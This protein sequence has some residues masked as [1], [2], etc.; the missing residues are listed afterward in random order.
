VSAAAPLLFTSLLFAANTTL[1][2][3]AEWGDED[4]DDVTVLEGE[5]RAER[6]PPITTERS[7]RPSELASAQPENALEGIAGL[8]LVRDGGPLAPARLQLRG[9]RGARVHAELGGLALDDPATGAI[10]PA[11]WP[12]LLAPHVT[13]TGGASSGAPGG[14]L[15][16]DADTP[17]GADVFLRAGLGTLQTTRLDASASA[18]TPAGGFV[19]GG[20]TAA[21]TQGDF[22]Y[23]PFANASD[24]A[25]RTNNDQR[26]ASLFL[27]AGG[28]TE[29]GRSDVLLFAAAREGGV[30]GFATAPTDALRARRLFLGARAALAHDADPA[31]VTLAVDGRF[32]QRSTWQRRVA[33]TSVT[34]FSWGANTTTTIHQL[35]DGVASARGRV[36]ADHLLAE[37]GLTR[38]RGGVHADAEHPL[39]ATGD[40][41][42]VGAVGLEVLTPA[43]STSTGLTLLPDLS[44]GLDARLLSGLRAS[45][46][47]GHAG[48]APTLDEL[49]APRGVV[50]GNPDLQPE[51]ATD[52]ELALL[53]KL[54]DIVGLRFATFAGR[55]EDTILFVNRNAF[56][57]APVNTGP[58]WRA[59]VEGTLRVQP[60]PLLAGEVTGQTL[61]SFVEATGGALPVAPPFAAHM[62]AQLGNS[63]GAQ[64]AATLRARAGAPSTL[65]G[66]LPTDGYALVDV[67][68]RFPLGPAVYLT[69]AVTNVLDTLDARDVNLLPLPGRQLFIAIEVRS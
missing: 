14:R 3:E 2:D 6:A 48:R 9:L 13:L 29:L 19:Q 26:L 43:A 20:A 61:A 17:L 8:T 15:R 28:A 56:E 60:H 11:L 46:R 32:S 27:R 33:P 38:L 39:T 37:H 45:L 10:D 41:R 51:R 36:G 30:P 34:S 49:Y 21:L 25:T 5:V 59:G 12:L 69:A 68:G 50:L 52:V 64:L 44:V 53:A 18:A 7:L 31:S 57:V 67:T 16:L 58:L 54:G 47:V 42:V 62:S 65:F 66:T 24:V 4:E 1:A 35:G 55:L 40:L 63:R 23:R 22:L